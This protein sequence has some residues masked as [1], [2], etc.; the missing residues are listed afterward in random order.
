VGVA[1]EDGVETTGTGPIGVGGGGATDG[2]AIACRSGDD[3]RVVGLRRI[4]AGAASIAF[5]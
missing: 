2:E 1:F 4:S 5:S 3:G